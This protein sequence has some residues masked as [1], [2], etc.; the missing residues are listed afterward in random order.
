ME[1]CTIV[2]VSQVTALIY[3]TS[4]HRLGHTSGYYC[5]GNIIAWGIDNKPLH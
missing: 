2:R 1:L 5:L 3:I 4:D